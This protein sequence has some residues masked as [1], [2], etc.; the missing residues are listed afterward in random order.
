MKYNSL[1]NTVKGEMTSLS[2]ANKNII[3]LIKRV[4]K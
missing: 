1:E 2:P 4:F 3:I